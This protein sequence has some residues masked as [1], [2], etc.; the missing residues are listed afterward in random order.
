MSAVWV[1]AMSLDKR[2]AKGFSFSEVDHR[3]LSDANHIKV[4]G[5]DNVSD[6]E[7]H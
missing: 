5:D 7:R 4:V 1:F 3:L 2:A 6:A